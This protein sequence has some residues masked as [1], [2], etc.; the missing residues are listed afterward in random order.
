MEEEESKRGKEGRKEEKRKQC[1]LYITQ[2][3]LSVFLLSIKHV[4]NAYWML[5]EAISMLK[6]QG[7]NSEGVLTEN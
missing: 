6:R 2:M 5:C 1:P 7:R 4:W 3:V